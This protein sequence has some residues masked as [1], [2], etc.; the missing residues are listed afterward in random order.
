[1]G[2]GIAV[3]HAPHARRAG[4]P[5]G[6]HRVSLGVAGMHDE[7]S[8]EG[9]RHPD[10]IGKRNALKPRLDVIV[11]IVEPT[12]ADGD[13]PRR[14]SVAYPALVPLPVVRTGFARMYPGRGEHKTGISGGQPERASRGGLRL[15]DTYDS[16]RASTT[17]GLDHLID[18]VDKRGVG[19]VGVTINERRRPP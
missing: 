6:G 8:T 19:Q 15:A 3:E 11:V 16:G 17:R 14:H 13:S 12:L 4:V 7:R 5:H 9:R 18:V 2:S 10:L 1:M